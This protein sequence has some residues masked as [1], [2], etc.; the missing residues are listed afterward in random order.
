MIDDKFVFN[1]V[2]HAYDL[3]DQ[4]TQDNKYARAIP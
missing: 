4:N 1:A 2:S 3:S